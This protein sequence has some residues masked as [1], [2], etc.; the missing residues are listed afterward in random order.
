MIGRVEAGEGV[1]VLLDG[2]P[3][4]LAGWQHFTERDPQSVFRG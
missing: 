3:V 1:L 4:E 2:E